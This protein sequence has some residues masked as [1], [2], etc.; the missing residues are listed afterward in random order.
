MAKILLVEDNEMNRDMLSRR[1]TKKGHD[2]VIAVDGRQGVD[3]A[4]SGINYGENVGTCVTVS[5]TIGAALEAAEHH[6]PAI[7]AS[8]ELAV[9]SGTSWSKSRRPEMKSRHAGG[10]P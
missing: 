3:L 6:I 5:G 10:R 7:A 1:L 2:V 8:L 4:I 9:G